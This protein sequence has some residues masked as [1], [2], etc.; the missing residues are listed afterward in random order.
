MVVVC[1][2][3]AIEKIDMNVIT[4]TISTIGIGCTALLIASFYVPLFCS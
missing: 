1:P 2:I 3:K 4:R